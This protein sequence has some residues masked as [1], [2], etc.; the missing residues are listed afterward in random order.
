MLRTSLHLPLLPCFRV[1]ALAFMLS[2]ILVL[3]ARAQEHLSERVPLARINIALKNLPPQ[4]GRFQQIMPNGTQT[5]GFY[6]M[7]WPQR[8]RFSYDGNGPVVTVKD[9]FIAIQDA[10]RAEPNW[11]PVSLTPLALIRQAIAQ[12]VSTAMVSDAQAG[13]AFW[14]L[15][16][17]DPSGEMPGQ[18]TLFFTKADT[19]LYAWRL[20]DAQNLVTQ[21]RLSEITPKTQLEPALFHIDYDDDEDVDDE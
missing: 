18:A 4:S 1:L 10:P 12:G 19:T 20:I 16:L 14:A 6:H 3:P 8:V 7:D 15:T 13:D 21:L 2:H 5:G 11:V 17:R 9:S